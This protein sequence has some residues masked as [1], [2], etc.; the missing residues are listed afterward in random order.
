MTEIPTPL[1]P[2]DCIAI[3]VIAT[4]PATIANDEWPER[5][6]LGAVDDNI[7]PRR[8]GL[9]GRFRVAMLLIDRMVQQAPWAVRCDI[10]S[11]TWH[12][13]VIGPPPT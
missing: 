5:L 7:I 12:I 6:T 3:Q 4:W 8:I 1:I 13:R 11:V 10:R 9:E 2:T